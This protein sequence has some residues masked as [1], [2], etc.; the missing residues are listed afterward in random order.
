MPTPEIHSILSPSSASR[1]IA[2]PPS[3]RKAAQH[4]DTPSIYAEEG[5]EAH[6][7][8]EH[9]VNL[10]LGRRTDDPRPGMK[11]LTHE[12]EDCTDEYPLF[13][14]ER[15]DELEHTGLVPSVFTEVRLDLSRWAPECFGTADCVIVADRTFHVIDLKYGRGVEVSCEHNVQ[16]MMY[17]LGSVECFGSLYRMDEAAL[18]IFQPRLGNISTWNTT[19]DEL[20][21]WAEDVLR[22]AARLALE[23][24]GELHAGP[25]CRFCPERASCCERARWSLE[26]AREDLSGRSPDELTPDEVGRILKRADEVERWLSDVRGLASRLLAERDAV[27]GWKLVEGRSLRRW[28]DEDTAA[29]R[30]EALGCDPY[31]ERKVRS[32]AAVEEMLG[33]KTFQKELGVLVTRPQGKPTLAREADRRPAITARVALPAR[34]PARLF[35]AE[36]CLQKPLAPPDGAEPLGIPAEIGT[37]DGRSHDIG[38]EILF[39][40]PDLAIHAGTFLPPQPHLVAIC[41][42]KVDDG[43]VPDA[44]TGLQFRMQNACIEVA[45]DPQSAT[46]A[47]SYQE[48]RDPSVRMRQTLFRL[49]SCIVGGMPGSSPSLASSITRC[50]PSSTEAIG[51]PLSESACQAADTHSTPDQDSTCLSPLR[52]SSQR[53]S[54]PSPEPFPKSE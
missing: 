30:L 36:A 23:V 25:H 54:I 19:K 48:G 28:S 44:R 17:A 32:I 42:A 51:T 39:A 3:A 33:R 49:S 14:R 22:P 5:T 7:L 38:D 16:M 20:L 6:S 2:C 4:P 46:T 26:V 35:P 53:N 9:K 45:T 50:S 29:R 15:A 52:C 40:V 12:M 8:A 1:W 31:E 11:H 21:S 27:P 10:W 24:G 41:A 34:E 37:R 47:T 13:I 18:I 43:A